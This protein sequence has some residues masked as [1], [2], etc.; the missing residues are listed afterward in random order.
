MRAKFG[1]KRTF[2]VVLNVDHEPNVL[3][4][5]LCQMEQHSQTMIDAVET[6]AQSQTAFI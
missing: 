3:F 5:V 2:R 1:H 4:V 6:E